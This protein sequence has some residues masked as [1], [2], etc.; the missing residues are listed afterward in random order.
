MACF[1]LGGGPP[2]A[3]AAVAGGALQ[4]SRSGAYWMG[5]QYEARRLLAEGTPDLDPG[6]RHP[7][8]RC[9][10]RPVAGQR[11]ADPALKPAQQS[12]AFDR[13]HLFV[14]SADPAPADRSRRAGGRRRPGRE[15]RRG[16]PASHRRSS[17]GT[18]RDSRPAPPPACGRRLM[19]NRLSGVAQIAGDQAPS[20]RP[21]E[22]HVLQPSPPQGRAQEGQ[23][24]IASAASSQSSASW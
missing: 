7:G 2:R 21:R 12:Q 11:R 18:S 22:N 17:A 6:R 9:P 5:W 23:G 4:A 3:A 20:A 19:K 13:E 16:W 14:Q 15:K 8:L 1:G 24:V 10:G